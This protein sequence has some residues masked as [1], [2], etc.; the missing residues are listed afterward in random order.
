MPHKVYNLVTLPTAESVSLTVFY[1]RQNIGKAYIFFL[2]NIND[3]IV[4]YLF[5]VF[6]FHTYI[7]YYTDLRISPHHIN[8]FR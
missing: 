1:I 7:T 3:N 8:C 2:F 4:F 5:F 6:V